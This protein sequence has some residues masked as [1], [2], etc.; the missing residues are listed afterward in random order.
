MPP[1]P[2]MIRADANI[3]MGSGHVAR[4]IALAQRWQ[5]ASGE[6]TFAIAEAPDPICNWIHDERMGVIHLDAAPGSIEDATFVIAAAKKLSAQWVVVDG[7][8]FDADYQRLIKQ[9][10]LKLLLFDDKGECGPYIADVV[11]NQN[12]TASERMYLRRS[13]ET[14]LLLG[15]KYVVLRREF[16]PWLNRQRIR[17]PEAN[18]ILVTMGGSDPDGLTLKVIEAL[19]PL[20]EEFEITVIAG[21]GNPKAI[22]I[23][24]LISGSSNRFR[25]LSEVRDM[26]AIMADADLAVICGGGTLWELAFMGCAILTYSRPGIQREIID[27]LGDVDAVIDL[28]NSCNFEPS[29]LREE[30]RRVL[31]S[32]DLRSSLAQ[33]GR[34]LVDGRGADRVV[35]A[36]GESTQ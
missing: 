6:V 28:G 23:S 16:K 1:A 35:A 36:L 3:A 30:V 11:L 5:D 34:E 29:K 2:L 4:C 33:R 8:Q 12:L 21:G 26:A 24:K 7:Y 25:F 10:G 9:S 20:S 13:P 22:E 19:R 18:K 31:Q 14:R 15:V 32:V 27:A 17:L